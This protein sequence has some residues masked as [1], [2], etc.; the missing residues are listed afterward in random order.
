LNRIA[1]TETLKATL[2][3]QEWKNAANRAKIAGLIRPQFD[4]LRIWGEL[5]TRYAEIA[6][7]DAACV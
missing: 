3:G 5:T 7:S 4:R 2:A 1:L 6:G